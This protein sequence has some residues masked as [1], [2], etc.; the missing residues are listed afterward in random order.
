MMRPLIGLLVTCAVL[1][2]CQ[3]TNPSNARGAAGAAAG[4]QGPAQAPAAAT[5]EPT[6]P[7]A[8]AKPTTTTI[9]PNHAITSPRDAA[10]GLPT[11]QR[12]H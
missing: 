7:G 4:V 5:A 8:A 3:P 10:S 12:M 6:A 11:G 9:G 1:V 2:G